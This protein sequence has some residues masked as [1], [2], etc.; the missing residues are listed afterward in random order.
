MFEHL[1]FVI[2]P[3][4]LLTPVDRLHFIGYDLNDYTLAIKYNI[5][6][7]VIDKFR[8]I[9]IK[10]KLFDIACYIKDIDNL[11]DTLYI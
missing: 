5:I 3:K 1:G 7:K 4:S 2:S 8:C 9:L 6:A 11:S 10:C